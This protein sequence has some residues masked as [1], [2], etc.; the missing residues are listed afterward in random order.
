MMDSFLSDPPPMPLVQRLAIAFG[1]IEMIEPFD[2][3]SGLI[4]NIV[5]QMILASEG[6][7]VVPILGMM[8]RDRRE[9]ETR[10][11]ALCATGDWDTW[12]AGFVRYFLTGLEIL[13]KSLD[14]LLAHR[15]AWATSMKHLRSDA[16][17]WLILDGL[18]VQPVLD[19]SSVQRSTGLSYKRAN[20]AMATLLELKII[21]PA[22]SSRI[23]RRNRLFVAGDVV[24]SL[25]ELLQNGRATSG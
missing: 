3:G 5:I 19:V 8:T 20:A 7:P 24:R 6:Y 12:I 23:V 1:Q 2:Y 18:L 17:A 25:V 14:R 21:E 11:A 13:S 10:V 15:L 9:Y 22:P 4:S 16:A